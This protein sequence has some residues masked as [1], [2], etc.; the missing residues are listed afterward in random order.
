[1]KK[2]HNLPFMKHFFQSLIFP[3]WTKES[4]DFIKHPS[5][6]FRSIF[7]SKVFLQVLIHRGKDMAPTCPLGKHWQDIRASPCPCVMALVEGRIK[8]YWVFFPTWKEEIIF[9]NWIQKLMTTVYI[10]ILCLNNYYIC[11]SLHLITFVSL[12]PQY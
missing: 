11:T 2:K 1:M 5:V 7:I 10:S 6:K 3:C 12:K 4:S 9:L 8:L